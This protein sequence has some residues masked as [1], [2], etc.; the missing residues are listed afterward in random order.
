MPGGPA[1]G[2]PH[3]SCINLNHWAS[4]GS[5]LPLSRWRLGPN[6]VCIAGKIK[7]TEDSIS[8]AAYV[9]S[10]VFALPLTTCF[11]SPPGHLGSTHT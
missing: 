6:A 3:T 4:P 11:A 10:G 9:V 7:P 5:W 2:P 8:H 1:A